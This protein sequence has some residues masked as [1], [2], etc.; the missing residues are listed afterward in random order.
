MSGR[1]SSAGRQL[2]ADVAAASPPLAAEG[3]VLFLDRDGV[4]NRARQDY[5]K[6]WEEFQFLSGATE[7]LRILTAK[8]YRLVIVTNQAAVGRGIMPMLTLDKIH[9]RMVEVLAG[10]GVKIQAVLTCPHHPDQH[11]DCR[12]PEPGLFFQARDRMGVDLSQSYFVGDSI[13]DL[14]AA[15][16]AG[17]A[18][19]FL[20]LT[21]Y[22][23]ESR[24]RLQ[25]RRLGHVEVVDD[26]LA[27]ARRICE[28]DGR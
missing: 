22:G 3:R 9:Q 21:G 7:A 28:L 1:K 24:P 17:C 26:L 25:E 18:R 23:S 14:Q 27:A 2:Q 10:S 4:I 16:A 11:C 13:S 6:S 8:S 12:K 20:V 5:V 19:A 15:H